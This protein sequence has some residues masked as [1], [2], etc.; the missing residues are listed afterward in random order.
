MRHL[1]EDESDAKDL[2]RLNAQPWMIE[3]LKANP[4]YLGWGCHEDYMCKEGEGRDSRVIVASWSA[5]EFVLNDLNECVN[6]YFHIER[7]SEKCAACDGAGYNPATKQISE[8]FYNHSARNGRGWKDTITQDEADALAREGRCDA[9]STAE[10]INAQNRPGARGMGHDA[11]NRWILIETRA[12]RLGVYGHCSKCE[13]HSHVF[14]EPA[15]KLF[16]T[17]WMLHP[18]K[19]C[20]RGVEIQDVRQEDLSAAR[21]WLLE[22]AER[23]AARFAGLVAIGEVR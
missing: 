3:T 4:S 23:N 2:E 22:A 6:F 12:K 10:S 8:D 9:G 19:G 18:R 16:L 1:P 21:K 15:A 17:L 13:G 11:I 5:F 14:T 20:S 7:A